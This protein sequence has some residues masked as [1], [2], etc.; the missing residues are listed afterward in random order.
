LCPP[1]QLSLEERVA[2]EQVLRE[3]SELA[4]GYGLLQGFRKLMAGR[5]MAALN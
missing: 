1:E 4:T 3:D 2:L 5:D